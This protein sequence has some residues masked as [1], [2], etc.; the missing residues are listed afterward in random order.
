MN[1]DLWEMIAIINN[2]LNPLRAAEAQSTVDMIDLVELRS[3]LRSQL[4]DLR[5]TITEQYSER[6][7]YFVLFPLIA[8]CDELVKKMIQQSNQLEWPPMQ[9][10]FY[11]VADA[12][13]LFYELL[14]N[15][16]S[17][18]ETLALVYEVYYFCLQDGFCGR[19]SAN[20]DRVTTYLEK[21][22]KHIC[23][24]PIAVT[25]PAP[26]P[27]KRAFFRM[28]GYAYYTGAAVL[29][30]LVYMFLSFLGSSWQPS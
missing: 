7:A 10:E 28:P 9:Q 24:L 12:G 29:L 30:M 19:Y 23:L 13:D 6:D 18:P 22:R 21:L 4:E 15:A 27:A 17:K 3:M 2:L 25:Y 1:Q 20:P 5:A 11:Q 14:D 8:H 16:L 26:E